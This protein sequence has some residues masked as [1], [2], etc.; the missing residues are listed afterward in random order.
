MMLYLPSV[1]QVSI[2]VQILV[3]DVHWALTILMLMGILLL[4]Q[5]TS[6]N[7]VLQ[8]HRWY[9]GLGV[10]CVLLLVVL[11]YYVGVLFGLCGERPGLGAQC[12]NTGTGANFLMA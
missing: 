4:Q 1:S 6:V 3:S 11:L 2:C 7:D 9:G 5:C 12:C 8:H 10:S